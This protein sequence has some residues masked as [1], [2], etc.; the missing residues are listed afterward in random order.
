MKDAVPVIG[1]TGG[2][3]AGK[4]TALAALERLGAAVL[5]SDAIVHE[6]LL[7]P[8][9]SAPIVARFGPQ[10]APEGT[11]DRSALARCAF[12]NDADRGWLEGL[13]W[14]LVGARAD[15][16]IREVRA[17]TPP[18]RAAVIEVPLLFESGE[19]DG[20]DATI[21][22]IAG[23]AVRSERAAKR[24]HALA[25]ERAARQLSQEEKAARATFVV[26]NDGTDVDLQRELSSVLAK[27]GR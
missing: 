16:W 9:V 17:R 6:L 27:L 19:I 21:A 1:L 11:L 18:P 2:M 26:R 14:P 25:D 10:V 24:G 4:S 12:G 7:R 8:D 22:V 23:E 15:E 13:L 3:G 20:Y 5:S